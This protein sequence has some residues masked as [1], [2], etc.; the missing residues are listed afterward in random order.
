MIE[1]AHSYGVKCSFSNRVKI[2]YVDVHK[3]KI[4]LGLHPVS[5]KNYTLSEFFHELGHIVDYRNGIFK[6][7][8][9]VVPTQKAL[10]KYALRA[11]LH[12][13]ETGSKLMKKYFPKSRFIWTY[14][15][16]KW[17]AFLKKHWGIE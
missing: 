16:K 9:R 10:R 6:D 14:K 17:Q 1:I 13:D 3:S 11:E 4:F 2:P 12:T 7:Y 8:Y 5:R 15:Y